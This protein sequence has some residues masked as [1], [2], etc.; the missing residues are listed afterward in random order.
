MM[1]EEKSVEIEL[2]SGGRIVISN[3][4]DENTYLSDVPFQQLIDYVK[5]NGLDD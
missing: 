3:K 5:N 2:P 1:V 4:V